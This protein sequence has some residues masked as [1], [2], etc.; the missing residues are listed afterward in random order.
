MPLDPSDPTDPLAVP[1][2]PSGLTVR[3]PTPDDRDVLH[4]LC[5]ADETAAV[6]RSATSAAEVEDMLAPAHT[7]LEEDQWLV[8]DGSGR[9][10][11]WG[12]LWDHGNTAQQDV[13][14]YRDPARVEE[15]VRGVVLDRLLQRVAQRARERGY[16]RVDLGASCLAQD[17]VYPPTL[18]ARGF[19]RVRT[20][21]RMRIDLDAERAIQV[22]T[23]EGVSL[24]PF[25]PSD[26]HQWR[27]LY[28][29]V[30]V[31]FA[32]HWGYVPVAYEDYRADAD[33]EPYPDLPLW[34]VARLDGRMVGVARASGRYAQE[35]GGW[36]SELGVLPD[37]RGRGV[38]RALLQTSFEANRAA[39]RRYVG[40]GVDTEN[41]TG[42]VR[43]YESVGMRE[44]QQIY[45][46]SRDV[47]P[48]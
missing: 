22:E 45:A 29:V 40:L 35:G 44:D 33:A 15:Q 39:G 23:P 37:V 14:I 8:L 20:F 42:A 41:T 25:D 3:R 26:E 2:L 38:A 36:V 10:V 1:G 21:H 4:A 48:A 19:T 24:E 46:Y 9:P 13:D 47:L 5:L 6:G 27:E 30:D 43:L 28:R 31:S 12:L 17:A 32:Q 18:E 11:V 34:R 16:E 7:T